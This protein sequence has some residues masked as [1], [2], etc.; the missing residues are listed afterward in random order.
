MT[1]TEFDALGDFRNYAQ[2]AVQVAYV[3]KKQ[4]TGKP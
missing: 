4:E 1:Q 3:T 2:A